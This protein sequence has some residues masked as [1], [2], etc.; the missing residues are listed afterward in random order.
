MKTNTKGTLLADTRPQPQGSA[1]AACRLPSRRQLA[2][3]AAAVLTVAGTSHEASGAAYFWTPGQIQDLA[4]VTAGFHGGA[5]QLS[6]IDS[7]TP[8]PNGIELEVT[9]RIGQEADPFGANYG[10]GFARVSLQGLLG[11]PGL[12]ASASTS[13][14]LDVTTTTD[15]TVQ[16]FL[17]TDFTENGTTIDDGDATPDESFSFLFWEHNDAVASGGPT[18]VDFDF[19][20]GTEFTGDWG[21]ANPQAV[22]G[23]DAIQAWG[24]QLAKFS[25][26]TVGVPLQ[27]TIRLEGVEAPNGSVP[28]PGAT[29]GLL[30][31]GLAA[32]GLVRRMTAR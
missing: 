12:D 21:L 30:G 26:M 1:T 13:S 19:S 24:L 11:F 23:T 6:T 4:D 16:S 17:Q 10:L 15:L 27:A 3:G 28:E 20:A 29:L 25:G 32:L 5:G 2:L 7:I 31:L 8:I 9:Y 14:S 22:Q 18:A